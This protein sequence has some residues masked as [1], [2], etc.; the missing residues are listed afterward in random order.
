[1]LYHFYEIR[2]NGGE[3]DVLQQ[4]LQ[5]WLLVHGYRNINHRIIPIHKH[6]KK[7]SQDVSLFLCIF[8]NNTFPSGLPHLY[9]CVCPQY[10][11][12]L[13]EGYK[14][15]RHRQYIAFWQQGFVVFCFIFSPVY[16]VW[17]GLGP[18]A[19]PLNECFK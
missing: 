3:L 14:T 13:D 6:L 2:V 7:N 5:I 11:V 19:F 17:H 9:R 10:S 15:C 12:L 1:M 8:Y 18:E 16:C 4:L